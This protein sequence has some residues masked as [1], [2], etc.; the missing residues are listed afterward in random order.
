MT[1]VHDWQD[2]CKE[3]EINLSDQ[4]YY[5]AVSILKGMEVMGVGHGSGKTFLLTTIDKFLVEKRDL[6]IANSQR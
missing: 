1:I 6:L 4:Q 2:W 5:A 3:K